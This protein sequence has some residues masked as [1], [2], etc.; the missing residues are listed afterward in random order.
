MQYR[1][2]DVNLEV[3]LQKDYGFCKGAC[4][5]I[6][7]LLREASCYVLSCPNREAHMAKNREV[8]SNSWWGTNA[9]CPVTHKELNAANKHINELRSEA[10][11]SN[12]PDKTVILANTS[13]RPR[14]WPT[15]TMIYACYFKPLSF[16]LMYYDG[17]IN[18][19]RNKIKSQSSYWILLQDWLFIFF[20]AQESSQAYKISREFSSNSSGDKGACFDW[21]SEKSCTPP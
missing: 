18:T 16:R 20:T 21:I 14:F 1:W 12:L 13:W 15:E 11:Q 4:T 6:Y 2:Q 8:P 5:L 9:L 19:P 3:R 10:S 17:I 7:S